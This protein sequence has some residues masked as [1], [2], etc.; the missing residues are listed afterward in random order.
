MIATVFAQEVKMNGVSLKGPLQGYNTI[1][2]IVN[3]LVPFVITIG[4][5]MLFLIL[6]WGGYDYVTSQGTPEKIKSANAKITAAIIGFVLLVLSFL[7]TR[8]ISYI[9]GVGQGII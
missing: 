4:G 7:I 5:I 8:I 9:F 1:G 3:N 2:D 6:M